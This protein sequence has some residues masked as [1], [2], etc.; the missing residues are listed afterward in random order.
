MGEDAAPLVVRAAIEAELAELEPDEQV[1][2]MAELGLTQSAMDRLIQAAY[3]ALNLISFFTVGEDEV[4]AWTVTQGALAPQ[5]AGVIHSDM[6][7][8][9]IRAEVFGYEELMAHGSEAAVKKAGL[10][11]VVGKDYPVT[12]GDIFNV[13]FNV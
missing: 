6:E 1:E 4:R 10:L 8:G 7:K 9:F 2:F 12:N 11:K 3:S 13:R 5:A